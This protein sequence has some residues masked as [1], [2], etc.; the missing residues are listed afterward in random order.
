LKRLPFMI[1]HIPKMLHKNRQLFI[2]LHKRS[3]LTL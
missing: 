3:I 2:L 1:V